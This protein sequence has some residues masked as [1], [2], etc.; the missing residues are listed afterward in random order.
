MHRYWVSS[1]GWR[2]ILGKRQDSEVALMKA[3]LRKSPLVAAALRRWAARAKAS[4]EAVLKEVLRKEQAEEAALR[5]SAKEATHKEEKELKAA[6]S[7]QLAWRR[8]S[9][10]KEEQVQNA[11][12]NKVVRIGQRISTCE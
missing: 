10:L 1:V 7:I 2:Q 4:R 11:V 8:Y 5:W 6:R 12:C 3:T 9:A